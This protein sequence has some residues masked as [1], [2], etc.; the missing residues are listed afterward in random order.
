MANQEIH[1]YIY[2]VLLFLLQMRVVLI[3]F[4]IIILVLSCA[5][6]EVG[7]CLKGW[8][9]VLGLKE[10]VLNKELQ[11]RLI[12]RVAIQARTIDAVHSDSRGKILPI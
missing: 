7:K 2:T 9:L 3:T 6:A 10:S 8:G 12:Q 5:M 1:I 4:S 11:E